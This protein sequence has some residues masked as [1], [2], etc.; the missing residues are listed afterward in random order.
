MKILRLKALIVYGDLLKIICKLENLKI[1][2][3]SII[4]LSDLY[5]DSLSI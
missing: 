2:E 1:K 3:F 4:Y 5:N